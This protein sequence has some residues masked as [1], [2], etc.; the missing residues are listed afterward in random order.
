MSD[1][2]T[3]A[4]HSYFQE[5]Q[6]QNEMG[7]TSFMR[8]IWPYMWTHKAGVLSIIVVVIGFAAAGRL[9]P[10]IFGY[11]IDEGIEKKSMQVVVWVAIGYLALEVIRSGLYFL[12]SFGIQKLGNRILYELREKLISHVQALSLVY[13]D[14]NPVGRTV[15]RVTNDIAS[16]GEMFSMGFTAIFVSSIEMLAILIAMA[17]ISVKLTL[18]TVIVAP[19]L[20][21]F[22]LK[23]SRRIREIFKE[24]KKKLATIN[25]FTAESLNG[26]KILQLFAKTEDRQREFDLHSQDYKTLSLKTVKMFAILWPILEFFNAATMATA[27]FFGGLYYKE[28]GLTIGALTAF[29]LLVQSFFHPLR[30]ILERYTQF[31]NSLASADRIF[32][33]M[34]EETEPLSGQP[35]PP[36]RLDGELEL[37]SLSHRYGDN[38]PWALKDVNLKIRQGESLALVG[39]TGSGKT[40]LISLLQRLYTQSG[41]SIQIGGKA[42]KEISPRD[43]RRRVG[44]VLQDN[45]VFRGTIASNI[46]LDNPDIS[47]ERIEWAANEAGCQK[48]IT[49]HPDGLDAPIEERGANLSVGERQL[50]AFARVL[51]FDPDILILDEAT[52]N[53]D[54]MSEQLIQ[55]ATNRVIKGRTSLIIA[56][57]LSTILGCDRIAVLDKGR[58]IEVGS[59]QDLMTL[60]GKYH[61]L[62][63]SQFKEGNQP[64]ASCAKKPSQNLDSC[65]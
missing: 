60:G 56:H 44:V 50:I 38:S 9:L 13:F 41:G 4:R 15:T 64:E 51:A 6:V 57:R 62:Y 45:F 36:G 18:V 46:S 23:L 54:S 37:C 10:I 40:T 24:A 20:T 3:K 32:S 63:Q 35:L 47:R 2:K 17:L 21:W 39:R 7:F 30:V 58:L 52:A 14:K 59:H 55:E 48:L 33:L 5:D 16:L 22:S 26:M 12:Q 49:T 42:L 19:I 27:L 53:I 1:K 25:A 8:K 65:L 61:E 11:A 29:L 28:F 43:W 31:Q 34:E